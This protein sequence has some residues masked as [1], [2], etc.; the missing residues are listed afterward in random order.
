MHRCILGSAR[1]LTIKRDRVGDWFVII[2]TES[3][4]P[5]PREIKTTLGIDVGIRNLVTLSSGDYIE[6]PRFYKLSEERLKRVQRTIRK[7]DRFK[8]QSKSKNKARTE[9]ELQFSWS[10]YANFADI[11]KELEND[12]LVITGLS[13]AVASQSVTQLS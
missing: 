5:E 13:R 2:A 3:P 8:Q 12:R 10:D 6:P 7:E 11:K 1:T 9:H 4:D